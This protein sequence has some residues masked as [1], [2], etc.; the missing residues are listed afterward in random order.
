MS[1]ELFVY[2]WSTYAVVEGGVTYD[3]V[4]AWCLDKD[5]RV[6]IVT[7]S[8]VYH[9]V[10]L[11]IPRDATKESCAKIHEGIKNRYKDC[12]WDC[13]DLSDFRLVLRQPQYF[14]SE[15]KT[16]MSFYA[17][18]TDV[19]YK[20]ERDIREGCKLYLDD[21]S[22]LS[23]KCDCMATRPDLLI[24]YQSRQGIPSHGWLKI[25]NARPTPENRRISAYEGVPEYS[26]TAGDLT[27]SDAFHP[28]S[29]LC[30]AY[31]T[32]WDSEDGISFPQ[33]DKIGDTLGM[34]QYVTWN[35]GKYETTHK[36]YMIVWGRMPPIHN[37]EIIEVDSEEQMFAELRRLIMRTN[38]M[39]LTGYNNDSFDMLWLDN[40]MSYLD[41]QWGCLGMQKGYLSNCIDIWPSMDG[42][43]RRGKILRMPGRISNDLYKHFMENYKFRSY[44][45]D[46]VALA[47]VGAKKVDIG[48][49]TFIFKALSAWKKHRDP[50]LLAKLGEYGMRDATLV[51]MLFDKECMWDTLMEMASASGVTVDTLVSRGRMK[52][53]FAL[54]YNKGRARLPRIAI[55]LRDRPDIPM[56]GGAVADPVP[57][58]LD[59]VATLDFSG[60]YPNIIRSFNICY[61]TLLAMAL[62]NVEVSSL[63]KY[64]KKIKGWE[65]L[66]VIRCEQ[67]DAVHT[68]RFVH[69]KVL[70]SLL[71]VI[72]SEL[73][74]KRAAA[75]KGC[76]EAKKAGDYA[77]ALLLS[78]R[79]QALKLT[80]NSVFGYTGAPGDNS[81]P[82]VC[83]AVTAIGRML[84]AYVRK[85]I[86]ELGGVYVYGDTDSVMVY[87]RGCKS[88]AEARQWTEHVRDVINEELSRIDTDNEG[89]LYLPD[90]PRGD[91]KTLVLAI[92][93][94]SRILVLESKNYSMQ[95]WDYDATQKLEDGKCVPLRL[96][97]SNK[98]LETVI[99]DGVT[100]KLW[101]HEPG[102]WKRK[103]DG[104]VE[105]LSRGVVSQKRDKAIVHVKMYDELLINIMSLMP[106]QEAC[107]F[108]WEWIRDM[109]MLVVP[110]EDFAISGR[111]GKDYK[112]D[113]KAFMAAL[114]Q[115]LA[116]EG[117][118]LEAGTR[119]EWF[120]VKSDSKIKASERIITED[121]YLETRGKLV[122]YYNTR[123]GSL[124]ETREI[125]REYYV[126]N[127]ISKTVDF[128]F[129]IAYSKEIK[130][131]AERA[132][133]SHLEKC[134]GKLY[135]KHG[136]RVLQALSQDDDPV[137]A[138]RTYLP[139][140]LSNE[141]KS[142]YD[143][144]QRL[145][146]YAS[147]TP[148][149]DAYNYILHRRK[150]LEE[151]RQYSTAR[152][153]DS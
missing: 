113:S 153:G 40:R 42:R 131:A 100:K 23:I 110:G 71:G 92:E 147:S 78:V 95:I 94:I 41:E 38:P 56:K 114:A 57:A 83:L 111:M 116:R 50:S 81:C 60:L 32:E 121:E 49:H 35:Y 3:K 135:I 28:L 142:M 119:F 44:K 21:Y 72:V 127:R 17:P 43:F 98:I 136:G 145:V 115:R 85:R 144:Q 47:R 148:C 36:D 68:Y 22:E 109:I 89:R 149:K 25:A 59:H 76:A 101:Q 79:Q 2:T 150:V 61:G 151:I 125:D 24:Q 65:D 108:V 141:F 87:K 48:G 6:A 126:T 102:D 90:K 27:K 12:D 54:I 52:R 69:S 84:I 34:I 123:E 134:V 15:G 122:S 120:I 93:K 70:K 143:K 55:Q 140:K 37:T 132:E 128:T 45:L 75:V 53:T 74:E 124:P 133:D 152:H 73:L 91:R 5:S 118:P 105:L 46:D 67:D 51:A 10:V 9:E 66:Q 139:D 77:R 63:S 7:I 112:D 39:C 14:Y 64:Y 8:G 96:Q 16:Y 58:L 104:K 18:C 117:R 107:N 20:I 30:A 62:Q 29:P 146:T 103:Q 130:K 129:D 86:E 106:V 82:E 1:L 19:A 138:L 33:Y 4:V 11:A 99:E 31:D 13:P 26:V 80:A 97:T 137:A 88:Y